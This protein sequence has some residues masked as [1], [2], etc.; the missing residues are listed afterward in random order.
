[1]TEEVGFT[2]PPP[3]AGDHPIVTL[4][5]GLPFASVTSTTWGVE[6]VVPTCPSG[7]SYCACYCGPNYPH[8]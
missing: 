6:S 4:G 5:T 1:M 3:V 7:S 8:C 2:E